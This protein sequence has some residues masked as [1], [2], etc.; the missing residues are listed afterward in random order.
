MGVVSISDHLGGCELVT[1]SCVES[2]YEPSS[3][4]D[5]P[6]NHIARDIQLWIPFSGLA[7]KLESVIAPQ[8]RPDSGE[9]MSRVCLSSFAFACGWYGMW[10]K[11]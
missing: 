4:A 8:L 1:G 11:Q 6:R 10:V 9:S 5:E 7:T 2:G 3:M